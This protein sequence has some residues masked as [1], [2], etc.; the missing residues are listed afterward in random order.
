LNP[1][2]LNT[3]VQDYILR[4]LEADLTR[5]LLGKS[6]FPDIST[7]ELVEQIEGKIRCEKKLPLWYSTPGIYYPPKIS[8]EQAL[9][10]YTV[11]NAYAGFRENKTGKLKAGM[12]ADF[13]LLS[14]DL[15]K[16]APEKIKDVK[17]KRTIL[18]GK[19]VYDAGL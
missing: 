8:V 9:R 4:N 5:I 12:L 17:V 14:D 11:N 13:V 18:N 3:E 7:R 6:P 1:A 10:C 15:F 2:I 19:L 16:I